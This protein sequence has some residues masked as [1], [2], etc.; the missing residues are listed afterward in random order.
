MP[1]H[2]HE[3]NAHVHPC[4]K[5]DPRY[6]HLENRIIDTEKEHSEARE[7]QEKREVQQRRQRFDC[8]RK[9]KFLDALSKERPD[10]CSFVWTVSCPSDLHVPTGPLLE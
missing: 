8:P 2:W 6:G 9:V 1:K 10:P 7:E 5:S 3:C 4:T